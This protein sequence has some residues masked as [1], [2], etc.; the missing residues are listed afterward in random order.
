MSRRTTY[1]IQGVGGALCAVGVCL[2]VQNVW[3][4]A[5]L[6]SGALLVA[7]GFAIRK[8]VLF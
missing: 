5:F 6:L 2:T 7:A 1:I 3:A 8:Y 4:T